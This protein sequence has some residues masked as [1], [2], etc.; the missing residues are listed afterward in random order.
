MS[1][2]LNWL[3][4]T[5]GVAAA[6]FIVGRFALLLAIPPGYATPVWPSAGI[7]L[8]GLLLF[9]V[10]VWPGVFLGSFLVNLSTALSAS[11]LT[12]EQALVL[13]ACIGAGASLQAVLATLLVRRFVSFPH[14]FDQL[15]NVLKT[16]TIGG[17]LG[18]L[19]NATIGVSSLLLLGSVDPAGF[20]YSWWT[21]WLGD[22]IGV[23][24]VLPLVSAWSIELQETRLWTRIQVG[25]PLALAVLLTIFLFFD[26]RDT[27]SERARLEFERRIDIM[28]QALKKTV[29]SKIDIL[30]SI[31]SFFETSDDVTRTDFHNFVTPIFQRHPG[32]HG[33]S[34]NAVVPRSERH[35]YE[36]AAWRDG[37]AGFRITQ[38][39]GH[40]GLEPAGDR[41][42][43]VVV[44]YIEP[45][46]GNE[47][48]LGYDL[49]SDPTR[50]EILEGAR[51]TGEAR[52]TPPIRLVQEAGEQSGFLVFVPIYEKRAPR[53]T[54]EER[55]RNLDSFVSG[56]FRAGDLVE[57]AM[58]GFE[59]E[60]ID[61]RVTDMSSPPGAEELFSGRSASAS[62]T[63]SSA[64]LSSLAESSWVTSFTIAG[65]TWDVNFW[66]AADYR[67]ADLS[68]KPWAVLTSGLFFTSLLGAFLVVLVG[69]TA[70]IERV[71]VERT[72]ALQ[73]AH[74]ELERR[75]EV[76]TAELL[77]A[78]K[79]LHAEIH[80]RQ[81]A[82]AA[83]KKMEQELL[84]AQ[85]LE[86]IGQLAGGIAHDFNNL[87][88]AILGNLTLAME[89]GIT[90][91]RRERFLKDAGRAIAR[92]KSLT[93]QLLTFSKGGAPVTKAVDLAA[94][95]K[96]SCEFALRG[97]N[98]SAEYSIDDLWPAE[99]DSGQVD[100]VVSNLVINAAQAMPSGGVIRIRA[101]NLDVT[102][103]DRLLL[104]PGRYVRISVEDEG[105]GIPVEYHSKIF[106]PYFT[107]K[108]GGS[109]L[110]LATAYSIVRR[111]GGD[112]RFVSVPGVGTTFDVYLPASNTDVEMETTS[113]MLVPSVSS[114]RI[115]LMDDEAM[116]RDLAAVALGEQGYT[117]TLARDG[118]EAVAMYKNA[119]NQHEPF[120]GVILD[121]TVP[122]GM[123]GKEAIRRLRQIDPTVKAIVSSGYSEDPVLANYQ[124]YGFSGVVAKPYSFTELG[125][126]LQ[127]IVVRR[128]AAKEIASR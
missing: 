32:L 75:V 68:S 61:Y 54:V 127:R 13:P 74:D 60:G 69:R 113:D 29:E 4:R 101:E 45:Q 35:A 36:E 86:S 116:I 78:N 119:M 117:V 42:E 71:V 56:V 128:A 125:A 23:L 18:C 44:Y 72:E 51:D 123:G 6:Y 16:M 76:R 80:E 126:T 19:I 33:L 83:R 124:E 7:A 96:E 37:L 95:L 91:G 100:Q 66:P 104:E 110:G 5:T 41:S 24:V 9:G 70:L 30:S 57:E 111:H 11:T 106:D 109:G 82:Q 15:G 48:A 47:Q 43:H 105:T 88:T 121:L 28:A 99:V 58:L 1:S 103:E 114:A 89:E 22:T 39:D 118:E 112:L 49:V 65:R 21:W 87:L 120:D 53:G 92:A 46:E 107:T 108:S 93:Q 10:R 27:E 20:A 40:G 94:L 8:A 122:G 38:Q 3:A 62:A 17:P 26:V 55:R 31:V 102:Y 79:A 85:K 84:K 73:R 97:S 34:W 77:T 52:A 14:A 115:L 81:E 67:V 12:L 50:R 2:R 90:P 25:L 59:S 98:I 64:Q 63:G